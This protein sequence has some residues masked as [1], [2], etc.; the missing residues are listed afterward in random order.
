MNF[1]RRSRSAFERIGLLGSLRHSPQVGS[2]SMGFWA[3]GIKEKQIVSRYRRTTQERRSYGATNRRI[4]FDEGASV[5]YHRSSSSKIN[6]DQRATPAKNQSGNSLE[7]KRSFECRY[8]GSNGDQRII[9][10]FSSGGSR[11]G[12]QGHSSVDSEYAQASG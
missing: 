2:V 9:C 1:E 7:R 11:E 5:H 12:K 4:V 3:N 8:W 10:S 6:F